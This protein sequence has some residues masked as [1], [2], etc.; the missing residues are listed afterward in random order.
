MASAPDNRGL[1]VAYARPCDVLRHLGTSSLDATE[2]VRAVQ[3]SD[4]TR[5]DQFVA[6]RVLLRQR[7]SDAVEHSVHPASWQFEQS[8]D[9]KPSVAPGLP[10]IHFSI[11][12]ADGLV[13]VATSPSAKIGIDLE[14]VTGTGDTRPTPDQLSEH[15]T[16]WL[17]KHREADRWP[18]FL[19]LWTAKE[20]TSKALGLGCGVDFNDLEIDIPARRAYCPRGVLDSGDHIDLDLQT[21]TAHGATYCLS[22][23]SQ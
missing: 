18:A 22:V 13:A 2:R 23:A 19:Q 11:S 10:Q 17:Q 14:R 9:G 8:L 21:I 7:L 12:H 5:H 4:R 15:E 6:G 3:I 20:A 16:A 1:P